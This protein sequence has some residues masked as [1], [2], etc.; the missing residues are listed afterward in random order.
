MIR[1]LF[2]IP[3]L[4]CLIWIFYLQ[5]RGYSLRQGKQGFV[6]ILIF[7]SVIAAFYSLMWWL[8]NL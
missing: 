7:S 4:L 5:S 8:T 2:L 1:M 3:L 6:Y